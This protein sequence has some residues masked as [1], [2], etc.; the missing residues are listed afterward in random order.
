MLMD[1]VNSDHHECHV[2][3]Y[4]FNVWMKAKFLMSFKLKYVIIDDVF[5]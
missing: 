2:T 3:G 1:F 4:N 5:R